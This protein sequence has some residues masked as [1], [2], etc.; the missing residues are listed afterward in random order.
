[1]RVQHTQRTV[2]DDDAQ[3]AKWYRK[4]IDTYRKA[5]DEGDAA[6]A[7]ALGNMYARGQGVTTGPR[8][9][10][11]KRPHTSAAASIRE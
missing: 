11:S 1:M 7:T 10:R 9:V 8:P 4:A 3:A 5:A 6:A 2:Q